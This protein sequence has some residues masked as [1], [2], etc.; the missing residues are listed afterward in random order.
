MNTLHKCIVCG[1]GKFKLLYP[2]TFNGNWQDAVSFFSTN[3]R[4]ATHGNIVKCS[5][6]KFVFTNPQFEAEEYN[7]IYKNIPVST[8]EGKKS[9]KRFQLLKDKVLNYYTT[10]KLFD[11]GCQDG[12]FMKIMGPRF[13]SI[14]IDISEDAKND[15]TSNTIF[16]GD[17]P[18]I[19]NTN[20]NIWENNFDL[21]TAWDVLEHIPKL[22]EYVKAVNF[23]LKKDGLLFCTLPNISSFMAWVSRSKWNCLLIEH[24]WYFN[25]NTFNLFIKRFGFEMLKVIKI[26]YPVD[27]ETILK[28]IIQTYK[29]SIPRLMPERYRN[30]VIPLQIG[31]M[32]TIS[33]KSASL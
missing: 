32:L 19:V 2:A 11:L 23:I 1:N 31:L 25:P 18:E 9:E 30:C 22:E 17:F 6:C 24:I 4:Y 8:D 13:N 29:I 16:Y 3:R 27:M 15:K 28:R 21:V 7:N 33:K 26:P 20:K 10:G 14:G 12:L 5:H